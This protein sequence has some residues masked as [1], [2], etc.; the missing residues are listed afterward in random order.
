M[1]SLGLGATYF[2]GTIVN[3]AVALTNVEDAEIQQKK[4]QIAQEEARARQQDIL[5]EL[6]LLRA[7]KGTLVRAQLQI[8]LL[9]GD[10]TK[11]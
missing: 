7:Q 5:H 4:Q 9:I 3:S 10:L 1:L 11:L 6:K 2:V 8:L